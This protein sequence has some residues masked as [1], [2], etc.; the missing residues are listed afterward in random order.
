MKAEI[1]EAQFD[2]VEQRLSVCSCFP[3]N[4]SVHFLYELGL[5]FPSPSIPTF[6][7]A[8]AELGRETIWGDSLSTFVRENEM[9]VMTTY[10]PRIF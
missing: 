7:D 4:A 1:L 5:S 8:E 10:F 6:Q 2:F 3:R 9:K